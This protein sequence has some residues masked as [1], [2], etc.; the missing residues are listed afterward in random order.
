[1]KNDKKANPAAPL[2]QFK[3]FA[4]HIDGGFGAIGDAFHDAADQLDRS[5]IERPFS[6]SSLPVAYLHR[7]ATELYLKACIVVLHQGL[8]LPFGPG[9]PCEPAIETNGA[10]LP[11]RSVHSVTRLYAYLM[12]F[13]EKHGVALSGITRTD[14]TT[15]P[16][17]L[18]QWIREISKFDEAST[19]FRYPGVADDTKS[20]F[21]ESSIT[22][23][24][25][26]RGPDAKP[27]KVY[28]EF[29]QN[30]NLAG[31]FCLD[32]SELGALLEVLRKTSETLSTLH[33]ALRAELG[34][35]R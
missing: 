3:P 7:H 35:G 34:K 16:H 17:E 19:F 24:L 23:I 31:S 8:G 33:F 12:S 27:L 10:W 15:I 29:D 18:G 25:S 4:H 9:K 30:D 20:D 2:W 26:S 28:L 13:F 1:M 22:E 21:R 5:V 32:S 6:N 14:W 11:F